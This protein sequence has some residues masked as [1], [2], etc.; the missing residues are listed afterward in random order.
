MIKNEY[1]A[2]SGDEKIVSDES[3]DTIIV[4]VITTISI[5][6]TM[7]VTIIVIGTTIFSLH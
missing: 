7:I 1:G 4:I 2:M 5:A 3:A 6:M